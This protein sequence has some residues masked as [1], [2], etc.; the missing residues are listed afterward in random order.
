[1][2]LIVHLRWKVRSYSYPAFIF[3]AHMCK[4]VFCFRRKKRLA[5]NDLAT[6]RHVGSH[7]QRSMLC[8]YIQISTAKRDPLWLRAGHEMG[9]HH[10]WSSTH[11]VPLL[12]PKSR[13]WNV[14]AYMIV[15]IFNVWSL[16][17]QRYP[18]AVTHHI[19]RTL[20]WIWPRPPS[21]NAL[22][23]YANQGS[24]PIRMLAG[25]INSRL[26]PSLG[27]STPEDTRWA[28]IYKVHHHE[29]F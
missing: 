7:V 3:Y 21:Q 18:A 1:M 12:S 19:M 16:F 28:I 5:C 15:S 13:Q 20:W 8:Q 2:C 6:D 9:R 11:K 27:P 25:I 10:I 22:L 26:S 17:G 4:Q 14:S 29:L 24:Q 23:L